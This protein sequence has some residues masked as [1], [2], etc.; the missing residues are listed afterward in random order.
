MEA[1]KKIKEYFHGLFEVIFSDTKSYQYSVKNIDLKV[2]DGKYDALIKYIL[3]GS[4]GILQDTPLNLL[5]RRASTKFNDSDAEAIIT[6]NTIISLLNCK[7]KEDMVE[8]SAKYIKDFQSKKQH[9]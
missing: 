4:R 9:K 3:I 1:L 7:S 8:K 6:M 2:R 5:I